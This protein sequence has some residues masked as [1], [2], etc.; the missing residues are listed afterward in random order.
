MPL[1]KLNC[2]ILTDRTVFSGYH[3]PRLRCVA[4]FRRFSPDMPLTTV[5]AMAVLTTLTA[6]SRP[7]DFQVQPAV[8]YTVPNPC[9]LNSSGA[10]TNTPLNLEYAALTLDG[11]SILFTCPGLN[12]SVYKYDVQAGKMVWHTP[13]PSYMTLFNTLGQLGDYALMLGEMLR[14]DDD[15]RNY[16]AAMAGINVTTGQMLWAY[17]YGSQ[18]AF[19]S[20]PFRWPGA[21]TLVATNPALHAREAFAIDALTGNYSWLS[22]GYACLGA[23]PAV[24]YISNSPWT[25]GFSVHNN[26]N[27]TVLWVG[28]VRQD[29][30]DDG[31]KD[32][33]TIDGNG[34]F[35]FMNG[36]NLIWKHAQLTGN[37]TLQSAPVFNPLPAGNASTFYPATLSATQ[38]S[39]YAYLYNT[40]QSV[41]VRLDLA[42]LQPLWQ[43]SVP[44]VGAGYS[45]PTI[46]DDDGYSLFLDNIALSL[47]SGEQRGWNVTYG[48]VTDGRGTI[49]S[50][51]ADNLAIQCI[52]SKVS[53]GL[54]KALLWQY[55]V[56]AVLPKAAGCGLLARPTSAGVLFVVCDAAVVALKV[57]LL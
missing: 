56:T 17:G 35:Y 45:P 6:A 11:Q 47:E 5:A 55:N 32:S 14:Y 38:H 57:P 34:D 36:T 19:C 44:P 21:N 48:Y 29:I 51:T 23:G 20:S 7:V 24:T 30:D 15:I 12:S 41:L 42:T 10:V 40:N 54:S 27:G 39:M 18:L 53:G 46:A 8:L 3:S 2:R 4:L 28:S 9:S 25:P 13:V 33:T 16:D 50:M 43:A 37:L 49:Y 26:T 1:V 52:N 31:S 22:G